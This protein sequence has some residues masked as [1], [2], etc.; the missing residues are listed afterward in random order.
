MQETF[1]E[2]LNEIQSKALAEKSEIDTKLAKLQ[3][4]VATSASSSSRD[5]AASADAVAAA[6][7]FQLTFPPLVASAEAASGRSASPAVA[8]SSRPASAPPASRTRSD[9]NKFKLLTLGF[10]REIPRMAHLAYYKKLVTTVPDDLLQNTDCQAGNAKAHAI[11]FQD[12]ASLRRFLRWARANP[13]KCCWVDPRT[14]EP[15]KVYYKE[16]KTP[17]EA[18]KGKSL[19]P[20]YGLVAKFIEKDA[21][22]QIFP[23]DAVLVADTKKG[24]LLLRT[25]EDMWILAVCTELGV[26]P[27]YH[28]LD[29]F[30]IGK[31]AVE[32][33]LQASL[34]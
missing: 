16:I 21:T 34:A 29:Q 12:N 17:D 9:P 28:V 19:S 20:Y 31:D 24:R 1:T 2:K 32:E 3:A 14:K 22:N 10:P 30:G 7:Q 4:L 18:A 33:H 11:V 26:D 23:S 25:A 8:R 5:G 27:D 6:R 13:D 15:V